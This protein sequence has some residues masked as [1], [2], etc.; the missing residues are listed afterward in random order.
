[1][2]E[3]H[4][5]L[6]LAEGDGAQHAAAQKTLAAFAAPARGHFRAMAAYLRAA[7]FFHCP[8][9]ISLPA[10]DPGFANALRALPLPVCAITRH[11]A[12]FATLC[13]GARCTAPLTSAAAL[14]PQ[15]ADILRKSY[16]GS[17]ND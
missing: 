2:A 12:P 8:L 7:W 4:T 1:M 17:A 6:W 3:L 13:E 16:R 15:L 10:Q 11:D 9:R 14:A 5:A